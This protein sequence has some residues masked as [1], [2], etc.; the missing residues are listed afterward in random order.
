MIILPNAAI[1]G[2]GFAFV[3]A[4]PG[5][6]ESAIATGEVRSFNH[7][8]VR[9]NSVGNVVIE[10]DVEIGAG[11]CVDRGTLGE[12]RIGK[13]SKLDNLVQVG[14]NVTIGENCLI[15]AEAGL[16]GSSKVGQRAVIGGQAG[17]PDHLSIGDDAVVHAQAGLGADVPPKA[18]ES[19]PVYPRSAGASRGLTPHRGQPHRARSPQPRPARRSSSSLEPST[20]LRA[21]CSAASDWCPTTRPTARVT[22]G[23]QGTSPSGSD[24]ASMPAAS[25]TFIVTSTGL[26]RYC[27]C[28]AA[29]RTLPTTSSSPRTLIGR[30]PTR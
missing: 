18:S 21:I 13:G 5:S 30:P 11:T 8:I 7:D 23:L 25:S 26:S 12:T 29:S 28:E 16:G 9:I 24:S 14:H 4:E 2:D 3:T 27:L 1:G 22:L 20:R 19:A 15:A 17:I 10:D 6:I